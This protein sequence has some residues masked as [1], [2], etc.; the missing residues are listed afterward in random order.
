MELGSTNAAQHQPGK[1]ITMSTTAQYMAN[2]EKENRQKELNSQLGAE[3]TDAR[4]KNFI[5][6]INQEAAKQRAQA[7]SSAPR[8]VGA[9]YLSA[10]TRKEH[11][12][13]RTQQTQKQNA[14]YAESLLQQLYSIPTVPGETSANMHSDKW[15]VLQALSKR[16]NDLREE[17]PELNLPVYDMQ[18]LDPQPILPQ[19]QQQ[20][21][22]KPQ[23]QQQPSSSQQPQE[24]H[25][26]TQLTPVQ[27]QVTSRFFSDCPDFPRTNEAADKVLERIGRDFG[28]YDLDALSNSDPQL[29]LNYVKAAHRTCIVEG[30]Y[31]PQLNQGV[32]YNQPATQTT[33]SEQ[34]YHRLLN[35]PAD[36]SRAEYY[37]LRREGR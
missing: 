7:A 25:W 33:S 23:A 30:E 2:L 31:Q 24:Q 1:E 26:T 35:M 13:L 5:N 29:A 15:R 9:D 16:L 8:P 6:D 28:V 22:V 21:A 32:Q 4:P 12:D 27:Q 37:R 18:R 10:E 14:E 36:E 3:F 11:E 20:A 19:L 34:D 17:A